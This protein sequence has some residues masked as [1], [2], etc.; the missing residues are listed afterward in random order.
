MNKKESATEYSEIDILFEEGGI[1]YC[2]LKEV[3]KEEALQLIAEIFADGEPTFKMLGYTPE[4]VQELL[5]LTF[6]MSVDNGV[7]VV[8]FDEATKQIVGCFTAADGVP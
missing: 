2:L 1:K 5:K 4:M 8:A 7:S 6:F 3:H